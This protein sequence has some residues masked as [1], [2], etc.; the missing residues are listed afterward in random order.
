MRTTLVNSLAAN[1]FDTLKANDDIS[2]IL[3]SILIRNS[4]PCQFFIASNNILQ[5]SSLLKSISTQIQMGVLDPSR[6]DKETLMSTLMSSVR[7][8]CRLF[9]PFDTNSSSWWWWGSDSA[10]NVLSS[11]SN[12]DLPASASIGKCSAQFDCSVTLATQS[13]CAISLDCS[14]SG[15]CQSCKCNLSSFSKGWD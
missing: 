14:L 2:A 5:K 8:Y 15:I 1:I 11:A 13:F 7:K 12:A 6:Q 3:V 4:H 10:S 9:N